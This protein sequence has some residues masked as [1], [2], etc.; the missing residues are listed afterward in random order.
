MISKFVNLT[1]LLPIRALSSSTRTTPLIVQKFG[2]TSLGTPQKL[3][4]I[5]A[6]VHQHYPKNNVI[7]V[8]SGKE[9]ERESNKDGRC[10][11]RILRR[12]LQCLGVALANCRGGL[13][14][15][16]RK[17]KRNLKIKVYKL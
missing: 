1:R 5:L 8:V 12:R 10:M 11:V 3:E 13:K 15:D 4:K 16:R 14:M 9:N 6:I 7:A 2:G 17:R